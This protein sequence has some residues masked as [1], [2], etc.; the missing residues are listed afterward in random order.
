VLERGERLDQSKPGSGL[1]LSIVKEI[2]DLYG[3]VLT[4][5][6]SHLGGLQTELILPAAEART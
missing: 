4:L 2:A 5:S 3:G 1:G 6:R